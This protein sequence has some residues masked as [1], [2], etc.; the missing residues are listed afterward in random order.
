MATT[1]F[2]G[3]FTAPKLV[4][5]KRIHIPTQIIEEIKIIYGLDINYKKS[6]KAKERAIAMLRDDAADGCWK[7]VT[8]HSYAKHSVS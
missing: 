1:A 6:W 2:V 3:E 8:I 4:N 5:H 7:N